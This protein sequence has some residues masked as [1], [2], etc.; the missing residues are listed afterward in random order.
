M[1]RFDLVLSC[2][3]VPAWIRVTVTEDI[4][5]KCIECIAVVKRIKF[6]KIETSSPSGTDSQILYS[7]DF[8][9]F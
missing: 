5:D 7:N 2:Q 1:I 4:C 6:K 9:A 8:V 3:A